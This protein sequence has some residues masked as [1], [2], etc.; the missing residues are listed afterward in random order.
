MV[1]NKFIVNDIKESYRFLLFVS[2]CIY[3]CIKYKIIYVYKFKVFYMV[4]LI[5]IKCMIKKIY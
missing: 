4:K 3:V 2:L 5:G 1:F